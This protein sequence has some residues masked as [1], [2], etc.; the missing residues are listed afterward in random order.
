LRTLQEVDSSLARAY[1][2]EIGAMFMETSAKK[3]TNVQDLFVEISR[4]LP[5]KTAQPPP[6]TIA[7][8]SEPE[9]SSCC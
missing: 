6:N 3:D 9:T 2:D 7:L 5:A 8:N 1:A 4:R